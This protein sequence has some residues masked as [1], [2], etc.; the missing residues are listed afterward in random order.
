MDCPI[1]IVGFPKTHE[2]LSFDNGHYC[3]LNISNLYCIFLGR[4]G[5]KAASVT[6]TVD[7]NDGLDAVR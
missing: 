1:S 5:T 2:Y 6:G 4:S 7:G 3:R